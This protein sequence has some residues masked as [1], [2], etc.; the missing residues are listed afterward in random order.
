MTVGQ[1]LK[2]MNF[3]YCHCCIKERTPGGLISVG[4]GTVDSV[5]KR[6]G[7][8]EVKSSLIVEN[9]LTFIVSVENS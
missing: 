4:G 1:L 5:I 2:E 8:L 9:V 7:H 6:F 3:L